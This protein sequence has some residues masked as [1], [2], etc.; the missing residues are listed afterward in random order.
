M[1]IFASTLFRRR[2]AQQG[3]FLSLSKTLCVI[4]TMSF[5]FLLFGLLLPL[6]LLLLLLL[7]FVLKDLGERRIALTQDL[8]EQ[9]VCSELSL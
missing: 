6:L 9:G 2:S 3:F 5:S 4:T 7:V 1:F 8:P